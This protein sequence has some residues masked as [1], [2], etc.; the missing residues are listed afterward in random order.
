VL[1]PEKNLKD[2]VDLPKTAKAE[3]KIIPVK[4]LDD[5]LKIALSPN[6]VVEPPRPRKQGKEEMRDDGE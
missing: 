5:V 3:L 2:L 1:L 4:H 6:V